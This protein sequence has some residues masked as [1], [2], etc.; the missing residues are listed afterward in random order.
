MIQSKVAKLLLEYEEITAVEVNNPH[1]IEGAQV[2]REVEGAVVFSC[3]LYSVLLNEVGWADLGMAS[4]LFVGAD[5]KELAATVRE[6]VL[7]GFRMEERVRYERRPK[8][9]LVV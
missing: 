6:H 2:L 9:S 4:E 1:T 8:G 5:A 3:K 7:S